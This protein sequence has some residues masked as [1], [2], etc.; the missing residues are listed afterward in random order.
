MN[1]KYEET[2]KKLAQLENPSKAAKRTIL[3]AI[4]AFTGVFFIVLI[5][6]RRRNLV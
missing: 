2:F 5:A 3:G 1:D 6:S 4:I